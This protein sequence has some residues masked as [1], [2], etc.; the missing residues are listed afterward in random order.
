M[1]IKSS[2]RHRHLQADTVNVRNI[3]WFRERKRYLEEKIVFKRLARYLYE[4]LKSLWNLEIFHDFRLRNIFKLLK[5]LLEKTYLFKGLI[6]KPI[7]NSAN[8][9]SRRNAEISDET[10]RRNDESRDSE[11]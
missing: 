6:R 11:S 10:T 5:W 9:I 1:Q 3:P 2:Y 8:Y 7:S 4:K